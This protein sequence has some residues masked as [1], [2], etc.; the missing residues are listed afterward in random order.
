MP[1]WVMVPSADARATREPPELS[2]RLVPDRTDCKVTAP[3][4]SGGRL[5]WA[6]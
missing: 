4:W 2:L 1:I 5:D 6:M 3:P